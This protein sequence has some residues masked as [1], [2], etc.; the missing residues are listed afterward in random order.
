MAAAQGR[1][2]R[3]VAVAAVVVAVI[4]LASRVAG[5]IR[6]LVFARVVGPGCLGDAYTTANQLPNVVFELTVGGMLAATVVPLVA[7][8]FARGDRERVRATSSALLGWVL[9]L[10]L[11]L[12]AL[13]ALLAGPYAALMVPDRPGCSAA[14][15]DTAAGLLVWFAPQIVLYGLAVWAS[16][17]LNAQQRFVAAAAAPLVS[18]V[19]VAGSYLVYG[20][21]EQVWV[22]GAGTTLGVVALAVT[23]LIPAG[24]SA[25]GLVRPRLRFPGGDGRRARDLTLSSVG[26]L[27]G[28]QV[29]MTVLTYLGNRFGDPGTVTLFGWANAIYLVPFA[30][31]VSPIAITM[32]PRFSIAAGETDLARRSEQVWTA[33]RL[34][35]VAAAVGAAMLVAA[36]HPVATLFTGTDLRSG[37]ALAAAV[38][39]IGIGLPGLAVLTVTGRALLAA[40]RARDAAVAAT[41]GWGVVVV[42][43]IVAAAAR[44]GSDT[45]SV[46]ALAT[47][48][49]MTVGG[50]AGGAFVAGDVGLPGRPLWRGLGAAVVAGVAAGAAGRVTAAVLPSATA[51]ATVVGVLVVVALVTGLVA[52]AALAVLDRP[53]AARIVGLVARRPRPEGR[54]STADPEV[55]R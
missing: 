39:W 5:F 37:D 48:A 36:A 29:G 38:G 17:L 31:L 10:L 52:A 11:P 54:G 51:V 19:V 6:W 8:A 2:L 25:V 35:L 26:A 44:Q 22:L 42:I 7:G 20:A 16:A 46:L 34:S 12:T 49:G 4:T 13:T 15:V 50:L 24:R 40:L 3:S 30:V 23:V 47:A 14:T 55:P 18:T 21:I 32:F 9:V 41:A 28:Q 27:A 43:G 53:D 1:G 45:L 33:V